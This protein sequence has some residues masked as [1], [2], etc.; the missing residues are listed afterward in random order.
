MKVREFFQLFQSVETSRAYLILL[1][2]S[3][4]A[5]TPLYYDERAQDDGPHIVNFVG[6]DWKSGVCMDPEEEVLEFFFPVYQTQ[7]D[8]Y[9]A[10]DTE[11][12]EWDSCEGPLYAQFT[13]T[14]GHDMDQLVKMIRYLR[15]KEVFSP[16]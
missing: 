9:P 7:Y 1:I 2:K 4:L 14:G 11:N 16:F 13:L 8:S 15:E 5:E 10:E 6:H 12:G 3:E